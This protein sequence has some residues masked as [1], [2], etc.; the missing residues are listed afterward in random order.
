MDQVHGPEAGHR[1]LGS[2]LLPSRSRAFPRGPRRGSPHRISG[3][4]PPRRGAALP[5]G[6]PDKGTRPPPRPPRPAPPRAPGSP[7]ASPTGPRCPGRRFHR[8]ASPPGAAR[9]AP[10]AGRRGGGPGRGDRHGRPGCTP[11]R[12]REMRRASSPRTRRATS[13][14]AGS[15]RR[16]RARA[17]N[18]ALP[19]SAGSVSRSIQ[20]GEEPEDST[21]SATRFRVSESSQKPAAFLESF[22]EEGHQSAVGMNGLRRDQAFRVGERAGKQFGIPGTKKFQKERPGIGEAVQGGGQTV[23]ERGGHRPGAPPKQ[24]SQ[25]EERLLAP[26]GQGTGPR[27]D[28]GQGRG[29]RIRGSPG[30]P[31]TG[32]RSPAPGRRLPPP[33]RRR[34]PEKIGLPAREPRPSNSPPPPSTRNRLAACLRGRPHRHEPT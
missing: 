18:R 7:P 30:R 3:S 10:A 21:S 16:S 22:G 5:R 15:P 13:A 12:G 17:A 25:A 24:G 11:G 29:H 33:P 9:P 19:G 28:S 34:A 4:R 27:Q 20:G 1:I 14:G 2:R 26:G 8:I 32:R 23:E 31:R 6:P